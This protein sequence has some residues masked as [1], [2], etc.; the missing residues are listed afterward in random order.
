MKKSFLVFSLVIFSAVS[1]MFASNAFAVPSANKYDFDLKK[2]DV[3]GS[4]KVGTKQEATAELALS[5]LKAF[6]TWHVGDQMAMVHPDFIAWH[7]SIAG[8]LEARPEFRG[9]TPPVYPPDMG[10]YRKDKYVETMT[11]LAYHNDI[12]RYEVVPTRV[13]CVGDDKVILMTDFNGFQLKRDEKT[14]CI[15]HT[16]P[17]GSPTKITVEF[18]DYQENASAPVQR[19]VYRTDSF[20]DDKVSVQVRKDLAEKVAKEPAMKPDPS[21]CKTRQ[22][23]LDEFSAQVIL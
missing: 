12:E 3:F 1:S 18:K 5:F 6:V 8:L 16:A 9:G 20:L 23:I 10:Q 11:F 7:S 21:T 19:L 13:D 4:C 17:F 22:M 14:G 2:L 15:T